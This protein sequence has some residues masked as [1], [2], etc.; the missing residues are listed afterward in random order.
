MSEGVP[1]ALAPYRD[2]VERALERYLPLDPEEGPEGLIRAM[3]HSVFAGGKRIR[4]ILALAAHEAAGG[5]GVGVDAVAAAIEMIHTYSLIHDDLPCM[6]DD[7]LRR[8]RPTCH[9]AFGEATALLAGDALLTRGLTLLARAEPIPAERRIR[10]VDEVGRAVD[11]TGMIGGQALDLLAETEPVREK[12]ALERIH[13][14][15]T[16]ALLSVSAAA[17]GIAAGASEE[18]IEGLRSYGAAFGL[19]FQIVD[20][21]LDV[22]AGAERM[23]KRTGKDAARG[24]ATFPG[25][26]GVEASA[27]EA[28]RL[29]GEAV[30]ALPFDT[31]GGLL[32]RV[33]Q[34]VV[35]RL[36]GAC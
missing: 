7:D 13:R 32:A 3:R 18:A 21:L 23:G 19:V 14:M 26:V 17:G 34:F 6:D 11:T 20:D 15:K 12:G 4:P 29:A 10:L 5:S 1:E 27:A 31:E 30:L 9:V 36:N 33:V 35:D 16:G 28:R 22:T 25:L 2:R 8:G 24:K